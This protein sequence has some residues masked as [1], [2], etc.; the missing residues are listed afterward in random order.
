MNFR[1]KL[2]VVDVDTSKLWEIEEYDGMES[3]VYYKIGDNNQLEE[4][5]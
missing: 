2:A 5:E 3:L 4:I 1:Q